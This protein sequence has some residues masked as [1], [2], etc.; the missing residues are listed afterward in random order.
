MPQSDGVPSSP[1]STPF[2]GGSAKRAVVKV[3]YGRGFVMESKHRFPKDW[4]ES[5]HVGGGPFKPRAFIRRRL[6]VTAAHCLPKL[7]PAHP[8]SPPRETTYP[9]LGQLDISDASVMAECLFADPV[10]DVAVLGMPDGQTFVDA[11]TAFE[12]LVDAATVLRM[13]HIAQSETGWLLSLD[14]HWTRCAVEIVRNVYSSALWINDASGGIV[15]GMSGSPILLD[16]GSVVGIASTSGGPSKEMHT[17]GG[18]Q[19][20]LTHCLPGELLRG[21]RARSRE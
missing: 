19:P 10:A 16:D 15:G 18:P 5:I 14:G 2:D 4:L 1:T 9:L 12:E 7:P 11:D 13:G 20:Q 17:E 8:G 3:G 21:L 6:V